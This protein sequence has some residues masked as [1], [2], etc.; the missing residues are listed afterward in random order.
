MTPEF[1]QEMKRDRRNILGLFSYVDDTIKAIHELRNSGFSDLVV[2]TPIPVH[3]IEHALDHGQK[4]RPRG[5]A[6]PREREIDVIRF[7]LIGAI[8]GVI[9]AWILSIGTA[10]AWPIP[11]G[12]MPIIALPPVGLISY[13]MGSLGAALGTVI[14]FLFQTK[15]PT[16][17]EEVYDVEVGCDK[18]GIA[19][20]NVDPETIETVLKIMKSCLAVSVEEKEGVLR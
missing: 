10:L 1:E 5:L 7:T 6:A 16:M 8:L 9:G 20:Q 17:K 13:E 12:G 3:D 11:Q 2:F 15:L 19:V 4:K 14:G 18:F